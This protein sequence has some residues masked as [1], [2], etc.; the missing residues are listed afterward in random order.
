MTN[1]EW[2]P[3]KSH[4]QEAGLSITIS[5][6][7]VTD[8]LTLATLSYTKHLPANGTMRMCIHTYIHTNIQ[9][10]I[11]YVHVFQKLSACLNKLQYI[12][13]CTYKTDCDCSR[14]MAILLFFYLIHINDRRQTTHVWNWALCWSVCVIEYSIYLLRLT[15][16]SNEV[17]YREF[18][19]PNFKTNMNISRTQ[20]L[21]T[22][23]HLVAKNLHPCQAPST[24]YSNIKATGCGYYNN[25]V[26]PFILALD[27][28]VRD[29][30]SARSGVSG[31]ELC[32]WIN[33]T[34][35]QEKSH[36]KIVILHKQT[37]WVNNYFAVT[38]FT[39]LVMWESSNRGT[40]SSVT[41][42]SIPGSVTEQWLE[43]YW[44]LMCE[45]S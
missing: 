19:S 22:V 42:G 12:G 41:E 27:G 17:N 44:L 29:R 37:K 24:K 30:P 33:Q 6:D 23:V 43:E 35:K 26:N 38:T 13:E 16:R 31:Q 4:A 14:T 39:M 11:L 8:T 28:N 20:I 21:W 32:E 10:C 9:A 40:D 15:Q 36:H 1:L 45:S 2:K 3:G 7:Y 18:R 5:L 25:K 34:P